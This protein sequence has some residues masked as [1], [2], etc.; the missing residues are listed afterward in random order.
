MPILF[1]E[2]YSSG[3]TLHS[4]E[5]PI[6]AVIETLV[7]QIPIAARKLLHWFFGNG[8]LNDYPNGK[9]VTAVYPNVQ[10]DSKAHD[11]TMVGLEHCSS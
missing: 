7:Y 6:A 5:F 10:L 3:I 4:L 2:F 8:T 1:N 11:L 9:I